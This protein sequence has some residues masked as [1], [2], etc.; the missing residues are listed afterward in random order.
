MRLDEYLR[1]PHH[2]THT[3]HPPFAALGVRVDGDYRQ[4]NASILQIENEYYSSIRPK[5]TPRA[6][7]TT[8]RALARGG[9]EY[10]E[11]APSTSAS[12]SR[13]VR[14]RTRCISWRPSWHCA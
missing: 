14:A 5:R 7:R 11:G 6:A 10:V 1:D 3:V 9:V 2:A 13:P 8:A 4:L 12:S